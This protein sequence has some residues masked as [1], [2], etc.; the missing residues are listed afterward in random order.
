MPAKKVK[1]SEDDFGRGVLDVGYFLS[2][3]LKV[4]P[5]PISDALT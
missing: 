5:L 2:S 1:R 4:V 3:I